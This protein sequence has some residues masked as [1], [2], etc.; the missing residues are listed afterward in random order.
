MRYR[1]T[2]DDDANV[3]AMVMGA[4]AKLEDEGTKQATP[5]T[6]PALLSAA[7]LA[8]I[9]A[10]DAADTHPVA[11][12]EGGHDRRALLAH[13]DALTPREVDGDALGRA[14]LAVESEGF[15]NALAWEDTGRLERDRL[16]RI[17]VRLHAIGYAAGAVAMTGEGD[18]PAV[19]GAVYILMERHD[20]ELHAAHAAGRSEGEAERAALTPRAPSTREQRV[21]RLGK[22]ARE[23]LQIGEDTVSEYLARDAEIARLTEARNVA[24]ARAGSLAADLAIVRELE[25]EALAS[26]DRWKMIAEGKDV[27]IAGLREEIARLTAELAE[28]RAAVFE[29]GAAETDKRVARARREGAREEREACIADMRGECDGEEDGEF[30]IR[31]AERI[32]RRAHAAAARGEGGGQG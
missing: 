9:R 1:D 13:L 14:V 32:I 17:G 16:K 20:R 15:D 21:E 11:S 12:T 4:G 7:R 10:A 3:H 19:E 24:E 27:R 26:M 18:D 25:A 31:A 23:L 22:L 2:R 28:A 8:E 29:H 30:M 6:T 5:D